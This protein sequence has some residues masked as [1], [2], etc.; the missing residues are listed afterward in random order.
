MKLVNY[1][2]LTKD[3]NDFFNTHADLFDGCTKEEAKAIC[4]MFGAMKQATEN[5]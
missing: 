4:M 1:E 3:M 2:T 5:I